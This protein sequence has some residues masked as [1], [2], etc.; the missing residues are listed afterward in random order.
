MIML[1]Y[2]EKRERL[3]SWVRFENE[4]C[5][6]WHQ[7]WILFWWRRWGISCGNSFVRSVILNLLLIPVTGGAEIKRRKRRGEESET[8]VAPK[9][10][11]GWQAI[12]EAAVQ[13]HSRMS[14]SRK[15]EEMQRENV[16]YML[17][18]DQQKYKIENENQEKKRKQNTKTNTL[19]CF[20]LVRLIC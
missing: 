11:Q 19:P 18:V 12:E 2:R 8:R 15:E 5:K 6:W 9:I 13:H 17:I 20:D 4:R 10:S 14:N 3:L 16:S 1:S 7:D